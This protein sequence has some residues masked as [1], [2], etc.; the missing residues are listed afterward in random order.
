M[1]FGIKLTKIL[2]LSD[3]CLESRLHEEINHS[4][5]CDKIIMSTLT[6]SYTTSVPYL[7]HTLTLTLKH[8]HTHSLSL[9][10]SL[11]LFL[12]HTHT[13]AYKH[14]LLQHTFIKVPHGPLWVTFFLRSILIYLSIV[15]I[16]SIFLACV[17]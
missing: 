4:D 11:S 6:S 2:Y 10:P 7:T 12:S 14:T 1:V 3:K 9:S 5:I 15:C 16:I 17:A 8:T 13:N